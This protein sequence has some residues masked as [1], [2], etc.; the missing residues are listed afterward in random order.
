MR[1]C[2]I[3][4]LV[5]GCGAT[6]V[7]RESAPPP[8]A[9][10]TCSDVGVILRGAIDVESAEAGPARELA[11]ANRCEHDRWPAEIIDCVAGNRSPITCLDKLTPEQHTA[12][13]GA[14]AAWNAQF[15]GV[16][17][18][19]EVG[20]GS[21]ADPSLPLECLQ[22]QSIVDKLQSCD[23]LPL[24]VRDAIKQAFDSASSGWHDL[25]PEVQQALAVACKA[26]YDAVFQTGK[27]ACGW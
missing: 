16:A 18:G 14:L 4:A 24:A 13:D 3:V 5:A 20:G 2:I 11:I 6:P 12:Y 25:P 17:Y 27:P 19:G 15:G 21:D 10:P 26:G 1:G 8:P 22:Y 9:R 23:K 7:V